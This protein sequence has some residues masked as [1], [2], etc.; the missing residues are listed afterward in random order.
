MNRKSIEKRVWQCAGELVADKGYVSP[1]DL[2]VKMDRITEKQVRDWRFGRIR[3]LEQ[4]TVGNLAQ[5]NTILRALG[6]FGQ[7]SGLKPS[8]T[9]YHKWGK[10]GK[11]R[12]RFS[13][14]GQARLEEAYATHYVKR[15][16]K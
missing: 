16:N 6:Q 9:V 2:L 8:F 4:V 10:G 13:K 15:K 7:H 5:M 1:V 12:L 3:Y 14:S 11:Q